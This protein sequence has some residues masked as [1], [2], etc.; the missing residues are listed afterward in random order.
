MIWILW[1]ECSSNQINFSISSRTKFSLHV[2]CSAYSF[3]EIYAHYCLLVLLLT[4]DKSI[5]KL[6][7]LICDFPELWIL[8]DIFFI[9]QHAPRS[10]HV[11]RRKLYFS[12]SFNSKHIT[13]YGSKLALLPLIH[14]DILFDC[15]WRVSS[16]QL[17]HSTIFFDKLKLC[18]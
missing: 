17:L 8:I 1:W 4:I 11:F 18:W 6:M 12:L 13:K 16:C 9:S 5:V 7:L 14:F 3:T 2:Y 15:W 10:V